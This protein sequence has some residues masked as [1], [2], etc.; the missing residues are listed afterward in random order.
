ME[1]KFKYTKEE[2]EKCSVFEVRVIGRRL[3][4]KSPTSCRKNEIIDR[5]LAIQEGDEKPQFNSNSRG[6]PPAKIL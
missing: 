2:L 4:V 3:G 1:E 6:R 5:I